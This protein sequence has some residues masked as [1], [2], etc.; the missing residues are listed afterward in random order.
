LIVK[1][2]FFSRAFALNLSSCL[3]IKCGVQEFRRLPPA[4]GDGY[5]KIDGLLSNDVTMVQVKGLRASSLPLK[6]ILQLSP[7]AQIGAAATAVDGGVF[8][9]VF[10]DIHPDGPTRFAVKFVIKPLAVHRSFYLP[11]EEPSRY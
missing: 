5:R 1:E 7:F 11:K 9:S 2:P 6:V 8:L 3:S 10:R 4:Y